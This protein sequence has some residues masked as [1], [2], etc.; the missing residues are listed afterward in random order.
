[1]GEKKATEG[2]V[3]MERN[4]GKGERGKGRKGG[5]CQ[6]I[7]EVNLERFLKK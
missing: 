7:L 3:S 1:M 5:R 2:N 4:E 6:T